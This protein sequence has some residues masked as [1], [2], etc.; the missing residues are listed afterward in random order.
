MPTQALKFHQLSAAGAGEDEGIPGYRHERGGTGMRIGGSPSITKTP[1]VVKY[2]GPDAAFI[3]WD[4]GFSMGATN[5]HSPIFS[6]GPYSNNG[7]EHNARVVAYFSSIPAVQV[8]RVRSSAIIGRTGAV[9]STSNSPT[10]L[11]GYGSI[12]SRQVSGVSVHGSYAWAT[13]NKND[14]VIAEQ[15][16]WPPLPSALYAE[17]DHFRDK[18]ATSRA[19]FLASLPPDVQDLQGRAGR[20][21]LI[22]V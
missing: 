16:W 2:V 15:V 13:F 22:G 5:A 20:T 8:E 6:A 10:F 4:N 9:S 7:R 12:I 19:A 11:R 18:L 17:I 14:D 3:A 1:G 21:H